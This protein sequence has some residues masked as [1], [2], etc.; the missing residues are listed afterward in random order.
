MES[1][2][3]STAY[4]LIYYRPASLPTNKTEAKPT[5]QTIQANQENH[6]DPSSGTGPD[7]RTT[8]EPTRNKYASTSKDQ[9]QTKRNPNETQTETKQ[10]TIYV[11]Y[12]LE[13]VQTTGPDIAKGAGRAD[14][15]SLDIHCLCQS[16]I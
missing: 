11:L 2:N 12:K 1:E 14:L 3:L 4:V 5:N 13:N 7:E 15:G 16:L 10:T 6:I 8:K 9:D